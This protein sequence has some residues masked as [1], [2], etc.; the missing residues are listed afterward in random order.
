MNYVQITNEQRKQML[1]TIGVDRVEDLY[2]NLPQEYQLK[3]L[4]SLTGLDKGLCELEL[5]GR[6]DRL[7]AMNQPT[8]SLSGG[9]FLGGGS[10][11]HF[12]PAVVDSL[13]QQS[14]FVTAYT[15]YQAEASQGSLQTFFE[16]Q[17]QICQL[18]GMDVAN[19]SLYEGATA[20][21]EAVMMALNVTGKRR[22]LMASSIHPNYRQV[23]RTYLADLPSAQLVEIPVC[24]KTGA[25]ETH[26]LE[27]LM[28]KADT[29]CVVIQSP[30]V[31]GIIENWSDLFS[32]AHQENKTL[33][34]A[35]MNPIACG[36]LKRPGTCKADIVVG[37]GQPLGIPMQ[38]GGPYLGLFAV[39]KTLMRK[40]PG[41]LVGQTTDQNGRPGYCLTLQTREQH[42]RGAKATS[43]ICTNQGLLA[44]RAAIYLSAMGPQGL[45][46][47]ASQCYHKAHYAAKQIALLDGFNLAYEG[48]FFN[49]FVI[50]CPISAKRLIDAGRDWEIG[51]GL[52]C[53]QLGIGTKNQ[54]LIAV[55]EKRTRDQIDQLVRLLQETR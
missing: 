10:Y 55:T 16:F 47:V 42:I 26:T 45:R 14:A 19:A 9:S 51:P 32:I 36:L 37:E 31:Y 4:L 49:E 1:Q 35:T 34:V 41:R 2:A 27:A 6:L 23:V 21:A 39:R 28:N 7:A 46:D 38:Y 44:I 5:T 43:N 53:D 50:N 30:N 20:V 52:A 40:M 12:V 8:G 11:D 15:P 22:V 29:A 3:S 13:A 25:I 18:T 54:L 48:D 17:T 33:A 24:K